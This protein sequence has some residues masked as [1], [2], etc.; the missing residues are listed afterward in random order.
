MKVIGKISLS[1]HV[2]NMKQMKFAKITLTLVFGVMTIALSSCATKLSSDKNAPTG[3]PDA[4]VK[5]ESL[6]AAYWVE[7]SGGNGTLEY[8]GKSYPI[9]V[10]DAGLG[11]NGLQKVT[12]TGSVYN[13]KRLEDFSGRYNGPRSGLT[14]FRGKQHAKLTN[15]KGVVLYVESTTTGLASSFGASTVT[16]K[17]MN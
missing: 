10:V 1:N 16:I 4:L 7:L 5:F 9:S 15:S 8:Q 2:L 17:I 14:L 3:P 13:L 6:S 12:A 11:G